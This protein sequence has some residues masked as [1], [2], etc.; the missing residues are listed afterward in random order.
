MTRTY[1]VTLEFEVKMTH[2]GYPASGP[3]FSSAGEP[4][5]PPEFEI[6]SC[7]FEGQGQSYF[8][9]HYKG[10]KETKIVLGIAP[11]DVMSFD[12]FFADQIYNKV[13]DM[14]HEDNWSDNDTSDYDHD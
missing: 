13:L 2:R 1:T 6:E 12:Q 9:F 10:Y 11:K 3:S 7:G 5:E 8:E 14:A 4:I